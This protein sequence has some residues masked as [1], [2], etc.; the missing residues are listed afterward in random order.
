[1]IR[2]DRDNYRPPAGDWEQAFAEFRD[3]DVDDENVFLRDT[4]DA[5]GRVMRG[6]EP[7][8]PSFDRFRRV[9]VEGRLFA[10]VT[11]RGHDPAVI[12]RAVTLFIETVLTAA[13]RR[14]MLC[15]LRG[16]LAC[17]DP[18]KEQHDDA[19]VLDYYLSHNRYHGV[20]SRR[21]RDLMGAGAPG[22]PDTERGKQFAI[23]DFVNH[24]IELARRH[25]LNKPISV[26]FSD[27]DVYNVRAVEDYIRRELG[28]EFPAV[29]FVVYYTS[30]PELPAGRKVVVSGQ[31][32]LALA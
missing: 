11:A 22:S 8:A 17:Y 16:Y 29:K 9:L 21:F 7:A 4:R 1:V 2:T 20:M 23:R 25:D 6:E 15:N 24:V 18:G 31:L 26:G 19:W 10:I 3:I 27:D 12:R 32:N 14:E 5:I 30:D 28:R 13:E